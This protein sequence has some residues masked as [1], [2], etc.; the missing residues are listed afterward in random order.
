MTDND[1]SSLLARLNALRPTPI[2]LN[3]TTS[4]FHA[5]T[6][7]TTADESTTTDTESD[8]ITRFARLNGTSH[9]GHLTRHSPV[10]KETDFPGEDEPSLD[11][12]LQDL[13]NDQSWQVDRSDKDEASDL[14]AEACLALANA[15]RVQEDASNGY[16]Q[17]EGHTHAERNP[18]VEGAASQGD[19]QQE[20]MEES[21]QPTEDEEAEEY[22]QQALAA[23]ALDD[24][25]EE[26][27]AQPTK[28]KCED[29]ETNSPFTHLP[30]APTSLPTSP[31]AQHPSTS[32]ELPSTPTSA[33]TKKAVAPTSALSSSR[34]KQA[35]ADEEIE[36]WCIIC[37]DDATVR[38]LGCDGDLYCGGCW[39][40]G[41]RGPDAGFEEKMHKAVR[42]VKPGDEKKAVP[43]KGRRMVGAS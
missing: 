9:V 19:Q 7:A 1:S 21:R 17:E 14:V 37:S 29:A 10:E 11:E 13:H 22:I 34:S 26:D 24:S 5:T 2:T 31:P 8:L 43:R 32:F 40:Q 18:G 15:A 33:P 39:N 25:G 3:P 23:A 6:K 41:H 20:N 42:F 38:C 16:E 36:T 12:L 28:A 4:S 27:G 30:S 35:F